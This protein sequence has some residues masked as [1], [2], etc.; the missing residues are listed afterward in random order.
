MFESPDRPYEAARRR[1]AAAIVLCAAL[2]FCV[3][4]PATGLADQAAPSPST[5]G[6]LLVA[7]RSM[8]DGRFAHTVIYMLRHD[9]TG[10]MGVVVNRPIGDVPMAEMLE[11]LGLESDQAEGSIRVHYGGPVEGAAGFV[12]HSPDYLEP[13][14]LAVDGGYALTTS[15]EVMRAIAGGGGPERSLLL[16]GYSGWGP[17]QLEPEMQRDDWVVVPADEALVFGADDAG[18]WDRAMELRG[19]DL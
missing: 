9:E 6:Q 4:L 2:A 11:G 12:L 1:A 18:K 7:A 10:A 14:S 13:D 19:V 5:A 16:F 8:P 15:V 17:G 3:A